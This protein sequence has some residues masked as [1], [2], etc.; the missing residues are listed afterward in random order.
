[1]DNEK[2]KATI[3]H[4]LNSAAEDDDD[5]SL[6]ELFDDLARGRTIILFPPGMLIF[7][8]TMHLP[9]APSVLLTAASINWFGA[10]LS[11]PQHAILQMS[12]IPIFT[13][14]ILTPFFLVIHGKKKYVEIT[15]YFYRF[16]FWTSSIFLALYGATHTELNIPFLLASIISRFGLWLMSTLSYQL[17]V[18]YMYRFKKRRREIAVENKNK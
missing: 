12:S 3:S 1:M 13:L 2:E 5:S 8:F 4:M 6:D 7:V 11:V 15:R 14:I 10:D 17:L 9:I 18:E 16:L